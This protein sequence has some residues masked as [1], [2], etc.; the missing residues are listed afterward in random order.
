MIIWLIQVLFLIVLMK[1]IAEIGLSGSCTAFAILYVINA[2]VTSFTLMGIFTALILGIIAGAIAYVLAKFFLFLGKIG[3][4]IVGVLFIL[5][6]FA[7]L[8]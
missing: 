5:A 8:F 3:S 1:F 2:A 4:I 7:L 6:I